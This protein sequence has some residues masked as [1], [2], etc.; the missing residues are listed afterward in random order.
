M[1]T[2]LFAPARFLFGALVALTGC[3]G[4]PASTPALSKTESG[5]TPAPEA[6]A[7]AEDGPRLVVLYDRTPVMDAPSFGARM[8]GELRLGASV[9]RSASAV[10]HA[11]CAGGWYAVR[12]RGFLCAGALATLDVGASSWLPQAPDL[13]R[14]LPYRY[15]RTRVDSVPAYTKVPGGEEQ[16][17]AEPDL[18]KYLSRLDL[19]K[20]AYGPS[21]NDVP[22]DARGVP[23][24]P[25]LLTPTSDG[26]DASTRRSGASFFSFPAERSAPVFPAFAR[27]LASPQTESALRLRKST[28]VAI[29]TVGGVDINGRERRFGLTPDGMIVPVDRLK[30]VLGSTFHGIDLAN[31]GLPVAFVHKSGV[32]TWSLRKGEADKS[33]DEL[34]RRAPVPLTGKFRTVDGIRF[35]E[36]EEGY[37]V[38]AQDVTVIV[39]RTKF[40]DFAKGS[41]KW[42]DVSLANQTI[43]AYE[44]RKPVYATLISSG[45]DVVGDPQQTAA[46]PR[47]TFHVRSKHVSLGIDPREVRQSF[48]IADAPW[49]LTLDSDLAITGSYWSEVGEAQGYHNI[50]LSPIDARRIWMWADP[51]VP[52]GWHAA[53]SEEDGGTIVYVRS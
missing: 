49:V 36:A 29:T 11:S 31:V 13:S 33:D 40:P 22:L 34:E 52:E 25:P 18:T 2:S 43:T 50:A 28:G 7:L 38:R 35:E 6:P 32:H 19:E 21:S 16:A 26:V 41:Q 53:H 23:T 10:S 37:W 30:P 47:G 3:K 42:L 9:V 39:R 17:S 46:T 27:E 15:G 14:P 8:L 20:E 51:Q 1:R 44:G 5:E 45:R 24:G 12:P 4:H 48:D